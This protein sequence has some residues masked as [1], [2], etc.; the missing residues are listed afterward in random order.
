[1][2]QH[3]GLKQSADLALLCLERKMESR[4]A[5]E[6]NRVA[7]VNVL[8]MRYSGLIIMFQRRERKQHGW[9][10]QLL[11]NQDTAPKLNTA[12]LCPAEKDAASSIQEPARQVSVRSIDPGLLT[13]KWLISFKRWWK[14]VT[15][16]RSVCQKDT[17]KQSR[18]RRKHACLTLL[19]AQAALR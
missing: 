16:T 2:K 17:L 1:M 8:S 9:N 13:P 7:S 18:L 11:C 10:K 12:L 3:T 14:S 4:N 5:V 15:S 6:K 19:N